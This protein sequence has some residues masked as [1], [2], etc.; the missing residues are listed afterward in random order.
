MSFHCLLSRR[1]TKHLGAETDSMTSETDSS[2]SEIFDDTE[3]ARVD[4]YT[5]FRDMEQELEALMTKYLIP[6]NDL[7]KL[8]E[9]RYALA[10]MT[11]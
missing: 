11:S 8:L 9:V 5:A 1:S 3:N 4:K 7:N 6:P 10:M 2:A